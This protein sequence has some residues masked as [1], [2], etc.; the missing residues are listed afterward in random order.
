MTG[1]SFMA[2]EMLLPILGLVKL[3]GIDLLQDRLLLL[4]F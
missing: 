4:T 3:T 2:L 1:I